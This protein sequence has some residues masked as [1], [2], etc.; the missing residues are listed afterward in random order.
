M[1]KDAKIFI[2]DDDR[3]FGQF[4]KKALQ[5][6]FSD[7]SYFQFEKD[8]INALCQRPDILILD[9][10]LEL[11]S[12]LEIIDEVQRICGERTNILYLSAQ[13]HVHVTLKALKKGAVDYIEKDSCTI[14]GLGLAIKKIQRLTRDFTTPLN[15]KLYRKASY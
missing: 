8:C 13:E 3:Y 15:I 7:V 5:D 11:C 14:V 1:M 4:I 2:L 6:N 10:R 9:H 12:G